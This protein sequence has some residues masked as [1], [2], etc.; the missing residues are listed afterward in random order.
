MDLPLLEAQHGL[1]LGGVHPGYTLPQQQ[2]SVPTVASLFI[3]SGQ[4]VTQLGNLP[5]VALEVALIICLGTYTRCLT[6]N[7]NPPNTN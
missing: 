1:S 3:L 7:M 2:Q 5:Q 4:Q 6:N